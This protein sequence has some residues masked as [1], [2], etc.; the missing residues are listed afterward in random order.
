MGGAANSGPDIMS[1]ISPASKSPV[2]PTSPS[3]GRCRRRAP[4]VAHLPAQNRQV[5][6]RR[7]NLVVRDAH[8][9][10]RENNEIG[11]FPRRERSEL[12]LL[13]RGVGIVER[14]RTEAFLT[15]H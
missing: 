9:V 15:R 4:L 2:R 12:L 1:S 10:L 11:V 6:A 7:R 3:A 14:I 5:D 13:E 8:D